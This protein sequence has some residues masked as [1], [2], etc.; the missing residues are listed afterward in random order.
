MKKNLKVEGAPAAEGRAGW[1]WRGGG[2]ERGVLHACMAWRAW[3]RRM[4]AM[5]ELRGMALAGVWLAAAGID[6]SWCV[7]ALQAR[8]AA[9]AA[10][11]KQLSEL[12]EA[13]RELEAEN[14]GACPCRS[15]LMHIYV[16][17][18]DI[19]DAPGCIYAWP[20]QRGCVH[21]AGCLPPC[22]TPRSPPHVITHT[23]THPHTHMILG[24]GPMW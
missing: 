21:A 19:C 24:S 18:F 13:V 3:L 17:S 22:E 2:C 1:G 9:A 20:E 16:H 7:F 15:H 14:S 23:P 8:M 11:R 10:Q 5:Q 4:W 6:G 12:K